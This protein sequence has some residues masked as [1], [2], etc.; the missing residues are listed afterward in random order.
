MPQRNPSYF[1]LHLVSDSTG[2]ICEHEKNALVHRT[3][4]VETLANHFNR[5]HD[6]RALLARLRAASLATAD[7]LTWAAAGRKMLEAYRKIVARHQ[8][9]VTVP[10]ATRLR[11]AVS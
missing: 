7:E 3:G 9:T 5:V 10:R 1:H 6:D 8:A 2:A 4:D 11:P